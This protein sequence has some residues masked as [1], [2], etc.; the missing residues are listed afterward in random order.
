MNGAVQASL[1]CVDCSPLAESHMVHL[2]HMVVLAFDF[3]ETSKL[4]SIADR[5]PYTP[6]AVHKG[7]SSFLL[8]I[9]IH[10]VKTAHLNGLR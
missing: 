1:W 2:D 7:S 10:S 8:F 5:Q 9:V 3:R 6:P 4:I